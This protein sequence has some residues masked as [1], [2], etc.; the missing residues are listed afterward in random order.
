MSVN[1]PVLFVEYFLSQRPGPQQ[2]FSVHQNNNENN[3]DTEHG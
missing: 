3:T 1:F 2:H